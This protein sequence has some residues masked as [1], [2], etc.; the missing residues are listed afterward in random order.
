MIRDAG[1]EGI[2]AALSRTN[3]DADDETKEE[4]SRP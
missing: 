3:Y 1:G 4:R 2:F